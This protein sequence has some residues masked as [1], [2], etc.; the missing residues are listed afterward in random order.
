[1][2][3]E[4]FPAGQ[5]ILRQGFTGTRLL[6][7]PRRR[8]RRAHRRRGAR[9]AGQGR[10]LRRDVAAARAS[11]RSPTSWPRRP[12]H[13]APPRRARTCEAFLLALPAGHVPHAPVGRPPPGHRQPTRLSA[14][15]DRA[16]TAQR[17]AA[18]ER[19]FPPGDYPVVV[20]GSGPGG[21]QASYYLRRLGI[22]HAVISADP[23]AGRH[24]PPLPVLPAAAVVDQAVRASWPHDSREYEW[25]DWNSLLAVEPEHRAV[26]PD[27]MD[28]TSEFPSRPEME[29]GLATLRGAHRP[30]GPLRHALGGHVSATA[31]ASCST[32]PTAT[33]AAAS[34]SSR[35]ASP[36]R[37]LPDTPGIEHAAHY[38]DTRDAASYAGQA[39][40]HHRQAELRLRAGQRPAPVG[41]PHHPGLAAAGAA[42]GQPAL[43]GR[44]PGALRPA[45][46]GRRPRRRRVHPQRL[47]RAHRA[48]PAAG[49]PSTPAAPTTA[50][51]SWSR[52]TRSS[53]RPASAA[54]CS[55]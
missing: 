31:S 25:Y 30:A 14:V 54:R 5:R 55:T 24:V 44:R 15:H 2:S 37:C 36:S 35:S 21:L 9:P 48:A 53:P 52:S 20:V 8:G 6:R 13:G 34:S 46:G 19:P 12:L 29:Q 27:L 28:G 3:E 7:D 1:M 50:S 32:P 41:Q 23:C 47:D 17:P 16:T 33:T 26:M 43:A 22:E 4:S 18:T 10:L 39:A 42:V 51:P 45:V 40:L 49:S 38:V 11:R